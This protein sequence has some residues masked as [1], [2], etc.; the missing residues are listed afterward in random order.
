MNTANNT[1]VI[2]N[3]SGSF[4]IGR[5]GQLLRFYSAYRF[6]NGDFCFKS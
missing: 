2:K 3:E 6:H 5:D 4:E 1:V